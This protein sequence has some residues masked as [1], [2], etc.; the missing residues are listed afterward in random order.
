[1]TNNRRASED[2]RLRAFLSSHF[3]A[4]TYVINIIKEGKSEEAYQEIVSCLKEVCFF[5]FFFLS[6]FYFF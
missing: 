1:M 6:F 3:D 2:H 5:S 4:Q